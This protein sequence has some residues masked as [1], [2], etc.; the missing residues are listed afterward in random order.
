MKHL[1]YS[2]VACVDPVHSGKHVLYGIAFD[3]RTGGRQHGQNHFEIAEVH[4]QLLQ[5]LPVMRT[6]EKNLVPVFDEILSA[7][8]Q[9]FVE[10][11][12]ELCTVFLYRPHDTGWCCRMPFLGKQSVKSRA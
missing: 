5:K 3:F 6:G 9:Q 2:Q 12:D 10:V 7:Q 11:F 8:L 4:D 1:E